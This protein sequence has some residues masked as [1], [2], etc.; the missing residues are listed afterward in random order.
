MLKDIEGIALDRI[1]DDTVPGASALK[2][3]LRYCARG[4]QSIIV[5]GKSTEEVVCLQKALLAEAYDKHLLTGFLRNDEDAWLF[6]RATSV[7]PVAPVMGCIA[8]S[9]DAVLQQMCSAMTRRG[10]LQKDAFWLTA[11]AVDIII[12]LAD[13]NGEV[14]IQN[15][16]EVNGSD[17]G[18]VNTSIYTYENGGFVCKNPPTKVIVDSIMASLHKT[19][20]AFSDFVQSQWGDRRTEAD[21]RNRASTANRYV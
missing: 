9:A 20:Q 18:F 14:V 10:E 12:M 17:S 5:A 3:F 15:V 4:E 8:D 6:V 19:K 7:M 11:N 2:S 16:A 1:L 21:N 13:I